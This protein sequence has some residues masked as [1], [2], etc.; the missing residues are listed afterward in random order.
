MDAAN[1]SKVEGAALGAAPSVFHQLSIDIGKKIA[2]KVFEDRGNHSEAHI[3]ESEL[4]AICIA[5]AESAIIHTEAR[6]AT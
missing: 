3:R 4:A 2:R 1:S 6:S 5:A